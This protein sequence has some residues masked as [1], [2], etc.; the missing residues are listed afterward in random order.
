MLDRPTHTPRAVGDD[1]GDLGDAP[2]EQDQRFLL[3]QHPDRVVRHRRAGQQDA[4]DGTQF[5]LG[6]GPL[7]LG[8]PT[9]V[10]QQDRVAGLAGRLVG[11]TDDFRVGRVRDVGGD[12]SKAAGPLPDETVEDPAAV[13]M[14]RAAAKMRSAVRELTR[15]GRE[16]ALETVEGATPAAFAT[17]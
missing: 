12:D 6:P 3:R 13:S 4:L 16:N 11:A 7:E 10:G 2:V 14:P 1:G 17:S 9:R 8:V 15:P 5:T